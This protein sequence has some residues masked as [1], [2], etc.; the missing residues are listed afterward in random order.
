MKPKTQQ[1]RSIHAEVV[2]KRTEP[3]RLI[4]D[5]AALVVDH[6]PDADKVSFV[7]PCVVH[8][9]WEKLLKRD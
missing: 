6:S 7:G 4:Y 1:L 5:L 3:G 9:P 8:E 2:K